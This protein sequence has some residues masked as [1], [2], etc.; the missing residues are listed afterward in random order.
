[1]LP[2]VCVFAILIA[3]SYLASNSNNFYYGASH[4]FGI[5]TQLGADTAGI[6]EIFGKTEMIPKNSTAT[7]KELSEQLHTLPQ[8]T[9]ILSYV[10]T[11]G[12]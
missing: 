7:Q 6:E 12:S 5:K 11:V 8:V 9:S 10:D 2:C 1:M 3:P 4:I